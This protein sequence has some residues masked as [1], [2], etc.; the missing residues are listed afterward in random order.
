MYLAI[1]EDGT[2]WEIDSP[3]GYDWTSY[4]TVLKVEL[5][6]GPDVSVFKMVQ[7]GW[8]EITKD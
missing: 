7:D 2:T 3:D 6:A 1:D 4:P 8:E 5:Y